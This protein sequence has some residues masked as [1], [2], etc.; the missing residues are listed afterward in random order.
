M[1]R[2]YDISD[3][4]AFLRKYGDSGRDRAGRTEEPLRDGSQRTRPD[5]DRQQPSSQSR[6]GYD[7]SRTIYCGRSR[8]YSLRKSEVQA[9]TDVGKF[10]MVPAD[11][12]ARWAAWVT[13][14]RIEQTGS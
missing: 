12:R 9:L 11:E 2:A 10:R 13:S 8:E 6:N 14:G 1:S 5:R 3:F 4:A 7:W